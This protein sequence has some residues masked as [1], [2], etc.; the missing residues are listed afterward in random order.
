[1]IR[2]VAAAAVFLAIFSSPVPTNAAE[3]SVKFMLD[4][5]SLGRHTPWYVAVEKG[6]FKEA[7]L[8]VEI[9]PSKGTADAI[10][11]V[12]TGIAQI[13]LIDVPSLVASGKAGSDM[14]IVAGAYVEAPATCG[15]S[16]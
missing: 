2:L 5:I 9:L 1:M 4:F 11:G 12:V 13:G 8:D 14:R 16:Q 3:Q 15:S 6:Y 10:R 7:G